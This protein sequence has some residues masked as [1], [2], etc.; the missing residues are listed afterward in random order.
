MESQILKNNLKD[1]LHKAKV[2][3]TGDENFIP[4]VILVFLIYVV[5]FASYALIMELE[6]IPLIYNED[7]VRIYSG[8][9]LVAILGIGQITVLLFGLSK[10]NPYKRINAMIY[11]ITLVLLFIALYLIYTGLP[12]PRK[13]RFLQDFCTKGNFLLH[14]V[15]EVMI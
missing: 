13:T 12:L 8:T 14:N 4:I 9:L 15:K 6:A 7:N 3:A 2:W 11:Y 1:Q 10:K 5:S